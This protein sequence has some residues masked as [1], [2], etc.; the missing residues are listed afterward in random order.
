MRYAATYGTFAT[1]NG[2]RLRDINRAYVYRTGKSPNYVYPPIPP[3]LQLL[4]ADCRVARTDAD[5]RQYANWSWSST[6]NPL[7]AG[8]HLIHN[9]RVNIQHLDGSVLSRSRQEVAKYYKF[10][11]G[12]Y[13]PFVQID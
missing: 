2:F 8:L 10:Y 1:T 6:T 13:A 11:Y 9:K 5:Q 7:A 4:Y 12:S 3:S